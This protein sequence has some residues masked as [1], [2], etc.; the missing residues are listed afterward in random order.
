MKLSGRR[1]KPK[2]LAPIAVIVEEPEWRKAAPGIAGRLRRAATLTLARAGK[3]EKNMQLTILLTNDARQKKLNALFRGKN[4]P[5]NVLS[6][7][8]ST[9]SK[10]LGDVAIAYGVS[11]GEAKT[12]SKRLADHAAHLA[13]HGVL[14]LLGYDHERACD[15]AIMEPLETR[16]LAS[17]G[18]ADPYAARKAA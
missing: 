8:S 18:V 10:Y 1:A 9:D 17:L 5:T 12:S 2:R 15:A 16:I 4:A 6:F 11:S 14:H 3:G 7:P 13:V